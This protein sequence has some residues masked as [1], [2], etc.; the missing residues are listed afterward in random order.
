MRID[1]ETKITTIDGKE[2][3]LKHYTGDVLLVVN[4]ASFCGYT[5]QY[6]GLEA[7]YNRY[8]SRGFSVLG[9]PCNQFAFQ[10]PGTDEGI[11]EFCTKN[12]SVTFPMFSKIKVNGADTHPLFEQLKSVTHGFLGN[13]KIQ[14]NFNKFL[15]GRDGTVLARYGSNRKPKQLEAPIE[16]A[17]QE[18]IQ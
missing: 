10:E 17:L 1:Y 8:K 2:T 4:T 3:D 12:Y 15:V 18:N 11:L 6:S 13:N 7:L 14:W 9:F 5:N 16:E